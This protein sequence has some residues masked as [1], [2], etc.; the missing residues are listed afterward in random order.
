MT[1]TAFSL[2]P[3]LAADTVSVADW[4]LCSVLLIRDARFVWLVLVPKRAGACE[5]IDLAPSDRA[6]LSAEIDRAATGLR[7]AVPCDKLNIAAL[8]NVVAQL[9]VHVIARRKTDAAWPKPV[10]GLPKPEAYDDAEL[11]GLISRL[12]AAFPA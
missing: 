1:T 4:P 11:S 9:H 10:W 6:L 2:D 12:N 3:R 5:I 7:N 8:G